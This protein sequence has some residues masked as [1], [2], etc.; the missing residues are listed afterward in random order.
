MRCPNCN[1]PLESP[2]MGRCITENVYTEDGIRSRFFCDENCFENYKRKFFVEEYHGEKIYKVNGKEY[3]PYWGSQYYF[4]LLEDCRRR[5]DM[6]T[7]A[8]LLR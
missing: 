3:I 4:D 1:K 6:G 7:M 2:R 5:I 8:Y